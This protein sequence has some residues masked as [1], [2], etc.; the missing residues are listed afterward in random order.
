MTWHSLPLIIPTST[1]EV[2][3]C[4]GWESGGLEKENNLPRTHGE[5][6]PEL[7]LEPLTPRA[8]FL[9]ITNVLSYTP[10]PTPS[11]TP[12]YPRM[13]GSPGGTGPQ[14]CPWL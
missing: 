7:R 8:A 9:L 4:C 2:G 11:P 14:V 13:L 10:T 5:K 3:L 1:G 12:P 6:E